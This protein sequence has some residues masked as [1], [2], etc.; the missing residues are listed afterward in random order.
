MIKP[1]KHSGF[2]IENDLFDEYDTKEIIDNLV[3]AKDKGDLLSDEE[4]LALQMND[5]ITDME[6]IKNKSKYLKRRLKA[7]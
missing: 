5:N 4:I 7:K 6:A 2:F 1:F 3:K